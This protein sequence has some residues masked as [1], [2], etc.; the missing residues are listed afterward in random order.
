MIHP[1]TATPSDYREKVFVEETKETLCFL[2][3]GTANV[4]DGSS[5]DQEPGPLED[6][7]SRWG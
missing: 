3:T 5:E 6:S 1:N 2:T 4:L 7:D